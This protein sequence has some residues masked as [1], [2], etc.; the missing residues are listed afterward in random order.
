MACPQSLRIVSA[1]LEPKRFLKVPRLSICILFILINSFFYS[2]SIFADLLYVNYH[3]KH[4][5]YSIE[6]IPAFFPS[7][8]GR[9]T[10]KNNLNVP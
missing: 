7:N 8:G 10:F 2:T 5:A 1:E 9:Q 6:T 3:P 4:I